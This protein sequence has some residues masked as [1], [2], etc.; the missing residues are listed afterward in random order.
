M[1]FL[2]DYCRQLPTFMTTTQ[3]GTTPVLK[4][5]NFQDSVKQ[6]VCVGV[7]CPIV[8][9][10]GRTLEL[11]LFLYC[12][13]GSFCQKLKAIRGQIVSQMLHFYKHLP[14]LSGPTLHIVSGPNSC[15]S[16]L[17]PDIVNEINI[18]I[19]LIDQSKS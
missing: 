12:H 19:F 16:L 9:N 4:I 5:K 18:T 14:G 1:F 11:Y 7:I 6:I 15:S 17:T 8:S 2:S 10:S 3:N 13:F